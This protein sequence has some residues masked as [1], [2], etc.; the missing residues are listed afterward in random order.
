MLNNK[1]MYNS[2]KQEMVPELRKL[3]VSSGKKTSYTLIA[4][5]IMNKQL[6]G[7]VNVI[8]SVVR[9]TAVRG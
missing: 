5:I 7:T 6:F 9:Q 1:N 8:K 4:H 3:T 2:E